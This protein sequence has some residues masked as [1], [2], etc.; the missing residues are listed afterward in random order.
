MNTVETRNI[1][2]Y[3]LAGGALTTLG[4]TS[5]PKAAVIVAG[6]P[7]IV[8][9]VNHYLKFGFS[10][11][12]VCIGRGSD[13]V[14]S[15]FERYSKID[16]VLLG[17]IESIEFIYTGANSAT[18]SRLM[19]VLDWDNGNET[20]AVS[21]SDIISD[22][23][24]CASLAIHRKHNASLTL[25]SVNLPTRFKVIGHDLFT[26]K[27]IGISKKPIV[28]N[29]LVMGGYYFLEKSSLMEFRGQIRSN[30]VLEE[31]IF[32]IIVGRGVAV[33]YNHCGFWQYVDSQRDVM[34]VD[35]YL[36]KV[37]K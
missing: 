7:L 12:F 2:V 5:I 31:D 33:H 1:P 13:Q 29:N 17:S 6:L 14:V 8:H 9:V 24:L 4:G 11:F 16:N 28:D 36:E 26:P 32:P 23:D 35:S 34:N 27:V 10:K 19:E 18:G 20:L 25:T 15:A 3:I 21:Y 37:E 30:V 22:V